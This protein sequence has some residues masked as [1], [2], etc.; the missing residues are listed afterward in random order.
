MMKNKCV[1][2][3]GPE[4]SGSMLIAR[5]IANVLNVEKYGKWDGVGWIDKGK[6]K[7]CHRSLPFNIPPQY[8]NI[9]K[10]ISDNKRNYD[11]YFVITTR[12][13]TISEVSRINRFPKTMEQVQKESKNARAVISALLNSDQKCFVFSYE[14]FMFLELAYL[15]R[16]YK[17]LGIDSNFIPDIIDGNKRRL[18]KR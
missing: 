9:A 10:W 17:F 1:F 13:L 12:D 7:V 18:V 2:T 11:I 16:L 8:P 15:K 6:H 14:T 5:I 4:S 3:V